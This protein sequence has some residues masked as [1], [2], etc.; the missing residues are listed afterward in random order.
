[1]V[2][3]EI[4]TDAFS[5]DV[6][7]SLTLRKVRDRCRSFAIGPRR[8]ALAL[9]HADMLHHLT[10][11]AAERASLLRL[12]W[13]SDIVGYA[14]R[15]SDE[16]PWDELR[17]R[18]PFVLNALSLLDL[19]TPLSEPV[20]RQIEPYERAVDGVGVSCRPL[21][22][23]VRWNRPLA[24]VARDV[25]DPPQWWLRLYYGIGPRRAVRLHRGVIHPLSVGWWIGRRAVAYASWRLRRGR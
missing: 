2:Q 23:S 14:G 16:I 20:R 11:H 4:H 3:V 15:F 13:V 24:A 5:R 17:E 6:P 1:M 22:E 9:G 19:V 7:G 21:S 8:T 12:I 10:R 18:T 25:F